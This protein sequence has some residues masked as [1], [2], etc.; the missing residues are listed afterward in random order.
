VI[1]RDQQELGVRRGDGLQV[2]ACAEQTGERRG[3]RGDDVISA[4]FLICVR[5]EACCVDR[6]G[7]KIS[8]SAPVQSWSLV[9][10]LL[11]L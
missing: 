2:P 1:G 8:C 7:R 6:Q 10:V 5:I 3:V 4:A 9:Q 11:L